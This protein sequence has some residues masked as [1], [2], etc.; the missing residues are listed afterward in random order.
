MKK[1]RLS[2]K[3]IEK[4]L[5]RFVNLVCVPDGIRASLVVLL[6]AISSLWNIYGIER[7]VSCI[8]GAQYI[9]VVLPSVRFHD[10]FNHVL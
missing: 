6:P 8:L 1:G 5:P 2:E 10:I 4:D 9:L 3:D 7:V